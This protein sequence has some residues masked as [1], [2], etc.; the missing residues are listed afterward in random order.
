M[1]TTWMLFVIIMPVMSLASERYEFYNGSRQMAMGGVVIATVND[2]TAL[3]TNPAALGKLRGPYITVVD[4]EAGISSN[5]T[6]IL[7]SGGSATSFA[8]PQDL[9]DQLVSSPNKHFHGLAQLFPSFVTTNYGIGFH[10]KYRYDAEYDTASSLYRYHYL[11][12]YALVT[13]FNLRLWEGRI[14]IGFVGRLIN[15][16]EADYESDADAFRLGVTGLTTKSIVKEGVGLAGDVGLLLTAP[17]KL[18][19][20][21]GGVL[22]DAGGTS[23]DLND[24]FLYDAGQRPNMTPPTADVG[25]SISPILSNYIRMQIGAEYR[26]VLSYSLETDQMRRVHLGVELNLGDLLYLRG[27]MNQRYWTGGLEF[28]TSV[29]QLQFTS[30]GEEIGTATSTREDRR[31]MGKFA[32]RF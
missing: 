12:D 8:D 3:L 20:S 11:N 7:Q 31:Y 13:G 17:W 30:Y 16:V 22:R 2:E 9:H 24:G 14:K 28:A 32:I 15:R 26:D 23:Y 19:P 4:P 6:Q 1:K 27:G 21:I 29:F 10:G 5:D 18:L 25:M